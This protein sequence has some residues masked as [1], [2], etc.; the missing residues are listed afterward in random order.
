MKQPTKVLKPMFC[1]AS[2]TLS[3][4]KKCSDF[5]SCL[6]I[7][8]NCVSEEIRKLSFQIYEEVNEV[9]IIDSWLADDGGDSFSDEVLDF[10]GEPKKLSPLQRLKVTQICKVWFYC[11]MML[12]IFQGHQDK[13]I[14]YIG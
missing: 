4:W 13:A 9:E 8:G 1:V 5:C 12:F 11:A 10:S 6:L 7:L 14:C 2:V 3:S